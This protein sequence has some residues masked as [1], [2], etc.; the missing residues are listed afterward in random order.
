VSRLEDLRE[1]ARVRGLVPEGVVTIQR[2]DWIGDQAVQV[3]HSDSSGRLG[4]RLVF[5]DDEP[6]LEVVTTGRPWSFDADGHLLRLVSEAWRIR[7]AWLFD[8]YLALSTS[9]VEPLPHQI[10]AVYGEMLNRHPLRFLLADDPGAGKTIMAG[11]LIKEL[12]LRGDVERCLIVSPGNL[13]EQW[14]DEMDEKFGLAFDI[15]SRDMIEAS[16]TGNPF[17]ERPLLVARMDQFSRNQDLQERLESAG[18]WDLVIVDEAHKMAAHYFGTELKFTG[19][20]RLGQLLSRKARHFL[21]MTA[22]PHNGNDED[23]QLFLALL[24]GDRFEG[25]YRSGVHITDP[26]DMMRRLVKEDLV[27]FDGTPLFPERIAATVEYELS[28]LEKQLYTEVTDYVRD[29]MNRVDRIADGDGKRRVNVGFALMALQRRLASSPEA[30]LRSIQRRRE[31]METRIKEERLLLQGRTLRGSGPADA[32]LSDRADVPEPVDLEDA[33][34]LPQEEL[35]DLEE[36]VMDSATAAQ[37][38]VELEV[39]IDRLKELE[40]L[41]LAL[42]RSGE[43]RKWQEFQTILDL[44]EMFR[45][46]ETRRKLIVFTESRDTLNY[47]LERIRTRVGRTEAV[48]SIHGGVTREE[49]R[50]IVHAFMNDPTV[51][52]LVANDAAGEGVNLQKAHLMVNYDLPWNPNRL[53]QRFGRIHRIGQNEVCR[54]W[55]LVA[56]NT[57]EGDVYLR[58]L[59]KLETERE[60]LGGKVFDVLGELF[61]DRPLRELLVEAIRYGDQPD[62]KARLHKEVE[63]AADRT[64][65]EELIARRSLVHDTL[66]SSAVVAI[67]EAMLR[68]EAQRLQPHYIQ[69]F[70]LDAFT[71]IG[72]AWRKRETGRFEIT[73]IPAAVR[74]RDRQIGR[75]AALAKHYE[76]ICFDRRFSSEPTRAEFVCPGHPMLDATLDLTWE[77]HRDILKQGAVLVDEGDLS[78]G[79]RLLF[80]LEHVVQDGRRNRH[81]DFQTISQRLLFLE[82]GEDGVFR[83]TGPAPYLD[84]RPATP[85][86]TARLS[87]RLDDTWTHADHESRLLAHAIATLAPAHVGEVR[88]RRLA[89]LDK[90]AHE[91]RARLQKE[92]NYWDARAVV[93]EE[94]ERAGKETRLS[95]QNARA[96]AD[97][98]TQRMKNRLAEID[99]QRHIMPAPPKVVGGVLVVP[100]RLVAEDAAQTPDPFA[101][102]L[103]LT[104]EQVEK[105]AM[106]AVFATERALG[107]TPRDVSGMRGIGYDIESSDPSGDLW[108]IEVKGRAVPPSLGGRGRGEGGVSFA[109][110]VTLTRTEMLCALNKPDRFRLAIVVVDEKGVRAPVYVRGYDFGQPGFEQTSA[111]FPLSGLIRAGGAPA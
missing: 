63:G 64:H 31:R 22:T 48:V 85:D 41:A 51:E 65:L 40:R 39:E 82:V 102:A 20:Y 1:N 107:R 87:A 34:D 33:E 11:L 96:R 13:T 15:L 53:E 77:Q 62:V 59:R 16:R 108:F 14:Q 104:R 60:A 86:E 101:A 61:S 110:M 68:A 90:V 7:L 44:P 26:S 71:R 92:I 79:P 9:S 4:Q 24:D 84:Y 83:P 46:N 74:Q 67:R 55:N 36:R 30:I 21:M 93:L 6:N 12:M 54:L 78:G 5:R 43:D 18:D 109:D 81:G 66:P 100:S 8:P 50:N 47:L 56:E 10:S 91:V 75:G 28:D 38:I 17:A 89:L 106:D 111:T 3:L 25:R 23:F 42:R 99:L 69:S 29:E 37:T 35:D 97:L 45:E 70:F 57:R 58:L 49:R 73:R 76:R 52:I 19:R 88:Q 105:M 32:R 27:R 95:A 2:I 98:L 80:F 94:Q 72:G 103:G